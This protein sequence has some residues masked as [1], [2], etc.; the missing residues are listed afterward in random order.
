VR[1]LQYDPRYSALAVRL[2]RRWALAPNSAAALTASRAYARPV[3]AARAGSRQHIVT[4]QGECF[5]STG[6]IQQAVP[7]SSADSYALSPHLRRLS[8]EDMEGGCHW[9]G[10]AHGA[11]STQVEVSTAT[12]RDQ[13]DTLAERARTQQV[14]AANGASAVTDAVGRVAAAKTLLAHAQ[15]SLVSLDE[16]ATAAESKLRA[17]TSVLRKIARESAPRDGDKGAE[18]QQQQLRQ[19]VSQL[20]ARLSSVGEASLSPSTLKEVAASTPWHALYEEAGR[21]RNGVGEHEG[22]KDRADRRHRDGLRAIRS[23]ENKERTLALQ[24]ST[25]QTALRDVAQRL[26]GIDTKLKAANKTVEQRTA[27]KEALS[28]RVTAVAHEK[29]AASD[30]VGA[31]RAALRRV[32]DA[33]EKRR[34]E[35]DEHKSALTLLR[36]QVDIANA[37]YASGANGERAG[38]RQRLESAACVAALDEDMD[39]DEQGDQPISLEKITSQRVKLQAEERL[40]ASKQDSLDIASL[41]EYLRASAASLRLSKAIAEAHNNV[42]RSV[43]RLERLQ[44]ERARRFLRGAQAIDTGLRSVFRSLC[45]HGDCTLEYSSEPS[46]LFTEGISIAVQPPHAEWTR[47]ETL[48]GGQ[49]ALVAVAL[50]LSLHEADGGAICLFDEIDAALDSQRV[51]ALADHVCTRKETQSVFVSH[52]RELIEASGRL[53]GTYTLNGGSQVVSLGFESAAA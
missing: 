46:I 36:E 4:L 43:Q 2:T 28:E 37:N 6:E 13:Y 39:V 15:A 51:K 19:E 22:A 24:L 34:Q 30:E 49:Q 21:L 45:K 44:S 14:E 5:L 50:N 8:N 40:F 12:L 38:K 32:E 23:L 26:N 17:K 11:R 33:L 35:R 41:E 25:A 47:F 53:L 16:A 7:P 10:A 42:A 31:V 27:D 9:S 52:R 20:R 29:E 48:S 18:L 3:D 1:C